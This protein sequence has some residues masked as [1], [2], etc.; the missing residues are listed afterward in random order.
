MLLIAALLYESPGGNQVDGLPPVL[1]T[2]AVAIEPRMVP[3]T[4][5]TFDTLNLCV[6]LILL[7]V[8]SFV[9]LKAFLSYQTLTSLSISYYHNK[10]LV[11]R[12]CMDSHYLSKTYLFI[13]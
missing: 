10:M 13:Y 7:T 12:P 9:I 2:G 11:N 1:H 3:R 8:S 5:V 6:N 4:S